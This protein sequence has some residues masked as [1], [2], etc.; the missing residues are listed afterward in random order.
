MPARPAMAVPTFSPT[1][2]VTQQCRSQSSRAV[3]CDPAARR[4]RAHRRRSDPPRV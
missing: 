4:G 2:V 1:G 3:L